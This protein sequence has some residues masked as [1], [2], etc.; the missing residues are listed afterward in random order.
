MKNYTKKPVTIQAVQWN[1]KNIKEMAKF[2]A[3][4]NDG[5]WMQDLD[6]EELLY[7]HTTLQGEHWI[8][9]DSVLLIKTLEG[10]MMASKGDYVI[11]GIKGEYYPCK[12]DIFEMTYDAEQEENYEPRFVVKALE[13]LI[14]E[15]QSNFDREMLGKNMIIGTQSN[16]M[17]FVRNINIQNQKNVKGVPPIVSFTIQ[18]DPISEVG[19]NGVQAVD[20]LRYCLHL[21]KSLN[22]KFHCEENAFTILRI[23]EAI[24]WQQ[25]RTLNRQR[26]GVEGKNEA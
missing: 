9:D 5:A 7:P 24:R 6:L 17:N 23:E 1:G 12:P 19:V 11:R 16:P 4:E 26:R 21:F 2:M 13:N 8:F 10:V 25:E 14:A 15:E 22:D 18:S 20:V 3:T